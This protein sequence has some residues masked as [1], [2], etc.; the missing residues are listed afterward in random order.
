MTD[1]QGHEAEIFY[2]VAAQWLRKWETGF[3]FDAFNP[4]MCW[5]MVVAMTKTGMKWE[6]GLLS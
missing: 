3:R 2:G 4:L 5:V 1:E 6:R